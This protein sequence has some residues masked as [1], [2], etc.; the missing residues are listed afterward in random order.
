MTHRKPPK[1]RW[2]TWIDRQI[3]E[4]SDAGAFDDLPGRGRPLPGVDR[5]HD[6][7]WWV[8][9][10]LRR[11]NVSYLPPTLAV[12]KELE[13]ARERIARASSESEVRSVIAEINERIVRVNS[14]VTFGPP[15]TLMPLDVEQVVQE[16]RERP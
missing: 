12:R 3:R 9:E 7:L 13:D 14:Q 2:E 10:K 15:S 4:A 8:K 16:W 5:P 6:E 11:E 1:V